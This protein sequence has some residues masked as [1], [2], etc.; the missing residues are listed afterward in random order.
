M[1]YPLT[2][3]NVH[4]RARRQ[5]LANWIRFKSG[6]F[7]DL[8]PRQRKNCSTQEFSLC[9]TLYCCHMDAILLS[10]FCVVE[11]ELRTW[12]RV[13]LKAPRQIRTAFFFL[14]S[15]YMPQ[16]RRAR[17]RRSDPMLRGSRLLSWRSTDAAFSCMCA[18]SP[19]I[20][21]NCIHMGLLAYQERVNHD[22]STVG[23]TYKDGDHHSTDDPK[24]PNV[25]LQFGKVFEVCTVHYNS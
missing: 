20:A 11:M 5:R 24:V 9:L 12:I 22:L 7:Q 23:G 25:V 17:P 18:H 6:Y 21:K 14:T 4:A 15:Q 19:M 8:I 13:L 1:S 3:A 2:K 10:C 16:N